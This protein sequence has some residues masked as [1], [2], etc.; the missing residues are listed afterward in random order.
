MSLKGLNPQQL[1]AVL[2]TEGPLLLL[3]GAGSGKTGVVTHRIAHLVGSRGV[4]P[5]R[6]LAVTFT[7][8]AAREMQERVVKLV[9]RQQ[10][11]G[12][13]VSTF[14]SLCARILRTD[15]ERLGYKRNFSIYGV[16]DQQH[17]VRDLMA[18]VAA[19]HG[20]NAD[21]ILWKISDAKNRLIPPDRLGPFMD[22]DVIGAMVSK[23]YPEYQKSLKGY[24][25]VDFDDLLMLTVRLFDEH[26]E[27]LERYQEQFRYL[28]VDEY[29]DTNAAQ[30]ELVRRL[31][32][33]WRNLCVVGDDDQSI[34]GWRGAEPGNIL[35]FERHFPGAKTIRLEQNY[36]STGNI[37][38][39]ANAVIGNNHK[40]REKQLWTA[41]S[42]GEKIS[43]VSCQDAD[44]E[45]RAVVERIHQNLLQKHMTYRDNAIL[46]RTNAQTLVFEQELRLSRIPYVLIG[47]QQFFD[48]KEVRDAIAYLRFLVNPFDEVNLLRILNYPR[49]GIGRTTADLLIR[50]SVADKKPL[51]QVLRD[52]RSVEG[53]NPKAVDVIAGFVTLVD[54]YRGRFRA[55]GDLAATTRSL[56]DT[57]GIAEELRRAPESREQSERRVENVEEIV[58]A[59]SRYTSRDAQPTL[60]GFLETVALLDRD[61]PG[62]DSK[63]KK[64]AQDAVMLMSLHSSKGLEFPQVFLPGCEEGFLPHKKS[65][66]ET[67][68]VDEER[69]LFY[70][71]ITRAR[72]KLTLLHARERKKYGKMESRERSRFLDE[73]PE[74]LLKHECRDVMVNEVCEEGGSLSEMFEKLMAIKQA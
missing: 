14:H 13:T 71:G 34:Y 43:L 33:K 53:I 2:H 38:A 23:V 7:N 45:A 73:I 28:M 15:I 58:N 3:A 8:K 61:E 31:A 42:T 56:F 48:R 37:L 20:L 19:D 52:A 17:L 22:G 51:W 32:G 4:S 57:I 35:D 21:Q 12:I 70:V 24:N 60:T 74:V 63:E 29:Q 50:A 44:D 27:V 11:T 16:S 59:V 40:R 69:R 6:I 41:G 55:G 65:V 10:A 30:F 1:E 49:R 54:T 47:G 64:L 26:P 36:R 25:A 66:S 5:E 39:A 62:S 9:G 46:L 68:D 67:F 18:N 72:I